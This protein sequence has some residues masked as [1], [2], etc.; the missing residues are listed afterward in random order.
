MPRLDPTV[1]TSI[2][3]PERVAEKRL[4]TAS[5]IG[6]IVLEPEMRSLPDAGTTV[7]FAGSFSAAWILIQHRHVD[8]KNAEIESSFRAVNMISIASYGVANNDRGQ[9]SWFEDLDRHR[10][11]E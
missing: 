8:N 1:C 11:A 3:T 2:C 10:F 7:P 4:P 5:I 9:E 6:A